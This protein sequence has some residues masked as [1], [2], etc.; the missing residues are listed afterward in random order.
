M[1]CHVCA[2]S[3]IAGYKPPL[4]RG[5]ADEYEDYLR[6]VEESG[7]LVD[8]SGISSS[9]VGS[10]TSELDEVELEAARVVEDRV[11]EQLETQYDRTRP[12][13]S[14]VVNF[15][16]N[17]RPKIRDYVIGRFPAWHVR[18]SGDKYIFRAK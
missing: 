15:G 10:T 13:R 1:F 11:E 18:M 3:A 4:C 14:I 5:H 6:L 16:E 9:L 7:N 8:I 2:E 12:R 17:I